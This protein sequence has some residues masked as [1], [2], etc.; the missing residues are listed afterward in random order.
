MNNE[1]SNGG[2]YVDAL[3][4]LSV[5]FAVVLSFI[6]IPEILIKKQGLDYIVES[7]V[8]RIERDGMAGAGLNDVLDKLADETGIHPDIEWSGAFLGASSKIQ[9]RERFTV[10]AK[11]TVRVKLIEPSFAAPVYLDVPIHKTVDGMSEVYWKD[12]S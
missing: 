1:N 11:Y 8:R 2:F 12:M 9:L 7:V 6:S 4:A 5:L 3:I 10:I